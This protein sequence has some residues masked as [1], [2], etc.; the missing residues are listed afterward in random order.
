MNMKIHFKM[1]ALI[2]T[3]GFVCITTYSCSDKPIA[4]Y[5]MI[6]INKKFQGDAHLIKIE[7]KNILIDTGD[8][9]QATA[10]LLPFLKRK[11]IDRIDILFISH[12]HKDHYQGIKALVK[13]KI[14]IPLAYVNIPAKQVCESDCCCD[15]ENAMGYMDYLKTHGTKIIDLKT[16]THYKL[17]KI[18][19]IA[20]LRAQK[21]GRYDI[22]DTSSILLWKIGPFRM[23]FTG[24][25]NRKLSRELKN[26]PEIHAHI[27]KVPHHGTESLATNAFIENVRAKVMTIPSPGALWASE[28]S[29]R[30]RSFKYKNGVAPIKLVSG[31][32]GHAV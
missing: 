30:V 7:D 19:E 16:D 14:K 13:T 24:D 10:S 5:H 26:H 11:K 28:R 27:L 29:K 6:N 4:Q 18:S 23:L 9:S 20:V 31:I 8:Y 22:N 17:H 1:I 25:L 21:S 12:L 15:W 32:E 2:F 3:V